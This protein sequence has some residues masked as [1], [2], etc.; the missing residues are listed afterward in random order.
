MCVRMRKLIGPWL[1]LYGYHGAGS[2]NYSVLTAPETVCTSAEHVAT[3]S[4]R[5]SIRLAAVG[6]DDASSERKHLYIQI[7]SE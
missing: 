6:D 5:S 4:H 3:C 2:T 7:K 1:N